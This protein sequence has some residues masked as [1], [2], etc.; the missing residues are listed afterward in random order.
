MTTA[1]VVGGT[2]GIGAAAVEHHRALGHDV[3]VWDLDGAD[4]RCDV[5]DPDQVEAAA[6][7]TV[8]RV[9]TP[10]LVTITAGVGHAGMLLDA[11]VSEWDRVLDINARGVWLVMRALARPM[12]DGDGGSIVVTSSVSGRLAD[13]LMGIYCV[14]K[15]ALDMAVAVAAREWA[16]KVRVNAVAPGVTDTPIL[17][18]VPRD[19][20]WLKAVARRTALGRLGTPDD[21]AEAILALHGTGW[22]T[23][24]SLLVD[25]G[26]SSFSPIDPLGPHPD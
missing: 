16:P 9:G 5:S 19:R 14:S 2:S 10:D 3:L 18:P 1:V 25:G 17:G 8:D 4:V 12:L 26:L 11:P 6:A 22:V 23:G 21:I 15:A 13:P 7:E 24:Q 20:G